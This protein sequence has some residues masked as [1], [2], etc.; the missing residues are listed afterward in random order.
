MNRLSGTISDIQTSDALSLV[1]IAIAE[2]IFSTV[3]IDNPDTSAY[4]RIGHPVLV[5][6]KETEVIIATAEASTISIQNRI[7]CEVASLHVGKLLCGITLKFGTNTIKSIIT[8]NA[9][10]QLQL[11]VND[12]VWALVK[13][14]EISIAPND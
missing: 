3:V 2:L 5:F 13:T 9:S 8:A 10:K 4:L 14:N 6:F 12:R 11:N 1:K 7:P